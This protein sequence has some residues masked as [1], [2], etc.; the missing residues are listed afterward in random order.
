MENYFFQLLNV[1]T[2]YNVRQ[3]EIHAAEPLVTD[4]SHFEFDIAIAKLRLYK[5][6]RIYQIAVEFILAGDESLISEIQKLIT[7]LVIRY[8]C[9]SSGRS[10]TGVPGSIPGVAR[11]F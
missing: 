7:P 2:V 10:L 9:F 8:N 6:P 11:F 5:L 1:R 3:F 4:S